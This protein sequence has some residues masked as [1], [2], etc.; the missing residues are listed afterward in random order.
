MILLADVLMVLL[1][2]DVKGVKILVHQILASLVV[3]VEDK[4]LIFNAFVLHYEKDVCVN[5]KE[6][7]LVMVI[8]AEMV[9]LAVKALMVLVSFAYVAQV[10]GVISVKLLQTP[11]GQTLVYMVGYVLA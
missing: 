3:P 5:Q 1:V 7:M 4:G 10:T 11:A 6:V 2:K 8:H 9:G